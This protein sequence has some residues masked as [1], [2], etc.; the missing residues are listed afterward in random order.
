M[1]V[2][3][4]KR[5]TGFLS[6]C[7]TQVIGNISTPTVNKRKREQRLIGQ[8]QRAQDC[9][10]KYISKELFYY[11]WESLNSILCLCLYWVLLLFFLEN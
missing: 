7:T 10:C 3:L 1:L 4:K 5:E 2:T 6:P 8:I 11:S 9:P